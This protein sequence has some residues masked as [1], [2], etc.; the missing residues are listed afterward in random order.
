METLSSED[1]SETDHHQLRE[2]L[3]FLSEELETSDSNK[4]IKGTSEHPDSNFS[5]E[6]LKYRLEEREKELHAAIHIAKMLLQKNEELDL[7]EKE[8]L[9]KEGLR[10]ANLQQEIQSL[11]NKLKET[12]QKF[13]SEHQNFKQAKEQLTLTQT[14]N[15][16]LQKELSK[17]KA[18]SEEKADLA[19]EH[20][21]QLHQLKDQHSSALKQLSKE[22]KDLETQLEKL[23]ESLRQSEGTNDSLKNQVKKLETE[24]TKLV[25][26]NNSLKNQVEELNN[27]NF[28]TKSRVNEMRKEVDEK[29]KK[30]WHSLSRIERLEEEIN[31]LEQC[32]LKDQLESPKHQTFSLDLELASLGTDQLIDEDQV[33]LSTSRFNTEQSFPLE[34]KGPT[35]IFSKPSQSPQYLVLSEKPLEGSDF[36]ELGETELKKVYSEL[37]SLSLEK[38][39]QGLKVF[40]VSSE[41]NSRQKNLFF[42]KKIPIENFHLAL[43]L[44]KRTS[45][46]LTPQNAD[47][48]TSHENLTDS[49]KELTPPPLASKPRRFTLGGL[50]E[51]CSSLKSQKADEKPKNTQEQSGRLS[52]RLMK[53]QK[54]GEFYVETATHKR[55]TGS[56]KFYIVKKRFGFICCDEDKKDIFLCEDDIILSGIDYKSFKR[57]VLKDKSFRFSFKIK[58]YQE[59]NS[60]KSKAIDIKII[61]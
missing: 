14:E 46:S 29:S 17:L 36:T 55:F 10:R 30:Y 45:K 28:E 51:Y 54:R 9:E 57:A 50:P 52:K 53:R 11:D 35:E 13:L 31:I 5:V 34:V 61:N 3:N 16:Q 47:L 25:E 59:N 27:E 26:Q 18:L 38:A 23:E 43:S 56:L 19:Q 15:H 49:N 4:L 42:N 22:N 41:K 37:K 8:T 44:G 12:E 40:K 24:Q 33:F 48:K 32:N 7:L 1:F 58:H 39:I 21:S 20:N 2:M 6:D 60:R